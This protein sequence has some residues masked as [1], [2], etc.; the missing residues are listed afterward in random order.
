ML[1]TTLPAIAHVQNFDVVALGAHGGIVDGDLTAYLVRPVGDDRAV[2]CDAGTIMKGL[3]AAERKG[4]LNDIRPSP[5][6]D[7]ERPGLVARHV[8]RAYLISHAHLDHIAGMVALSPDDTPKP[9]YALPSVIDVL[10]QHVFNGAV[11]PNMADQGTAPRLGLYH[12]APLKVGQAERIAGT[13]LTVS[14]Y[15]LSHAAVESTAFLLRNGDDALLYLG[16]TGADTVEHRHNLQ[17]LW[18][19]VAPLIRAHHLHGI[20]IECSYDDSRADARLFG[21]LSPHWLLHELEMLEKAVGNEKP[22]QG[23]PVVVSHIKPSLVSSRQPERDI[24]TTLRQHD[25]T[26]SRFIRLE[27]GDR[28]QF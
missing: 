22:L 11:W 19:A 12:Y 17:D 28:V 16:D 18:Q 26:G 4:S 7:K 8:V 14:A 2:L 3:E 27:Q 5:D 13:A 23:L 10:T 6:L 24:L 20:I 21:H 15:P 9:I 1:T 25:R